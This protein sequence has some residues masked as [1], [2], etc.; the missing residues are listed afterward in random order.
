MRKKRKNA[1][2]CGI[3]PEFCNKKEKETNIL[4]IGD[5]VMHINPFQR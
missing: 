3:I 4:V 5:K 1:G 2:D